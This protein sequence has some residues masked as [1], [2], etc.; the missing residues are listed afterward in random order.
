MTAS[1]AT[2]AREREE[3]GFTA[4]IQGINTSAIE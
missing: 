4:N 3:L 1:K 2:V